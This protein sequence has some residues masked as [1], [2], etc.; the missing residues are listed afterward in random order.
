MKANRFLVDT[1]VW[2]LAL[3]KK[4]LDALPLVEIGTV[5]WE[6]AF[7]LAFNL[8]RNGITVPYTNIR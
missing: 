8:R 6:A 5:V 4:R 1:S 2:I 7:D 3:L